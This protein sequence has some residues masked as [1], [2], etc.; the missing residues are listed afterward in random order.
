VNSSFKP[1]DNFRWKDIDL[2]AYKEDGSL[3]KG[4]TRQVLSKAAVKL[5]VN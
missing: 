5:S 3:F 4:V 1:F 2:L